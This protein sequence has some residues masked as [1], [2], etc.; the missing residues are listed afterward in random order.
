VPG[1]VEREERRVLPDDEAARA[2][3]GAR[4]GGAAEDRSLGERGADR[5]EADAV[6]LRSS[7]YRRM[8]ASRSWLLSLASA[9][10][11]FGSISSHAFSICSPCISGLS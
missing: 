9:A 1:A 5:G 6:Q 8:T 4:R 11:N 3:R 10:F 7:R 2:A